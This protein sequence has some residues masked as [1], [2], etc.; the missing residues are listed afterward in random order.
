MTAKREAIRIRDAC[1][2]RNTHT[3]DPTEPSGYVAW[4]EWAAWMHRHG[5]RQRKC[6]G[7]GLFAIWAPTGEQLGYD[8]SSEP[9]CLDL[10]KDR[11]R[12]KASAS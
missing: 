1:P 11:P 12:R 9:E 8:P 6:P 2:D 4:H 3:V 10:T 7:C 5:S